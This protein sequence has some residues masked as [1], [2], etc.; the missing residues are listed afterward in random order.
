MEIKFLTSFSGCFGTV[1]VDD[2]F[3]VVAVALPN[4]PRPSQLYLATSSW[5]DLLSSENLMPCFS[6]V[7]T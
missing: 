6:D 4:L 2:F 3:L 5:F 1:P 7:F